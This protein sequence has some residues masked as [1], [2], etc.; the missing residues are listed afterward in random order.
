M[1]KWLHT[2]TFLKPHASLEQPFF[3]GGGGFRERG[4]KPWPHPHFAL[5][6]TF[7]TTRH[8]FGQMVHLG[9]RQF[10]PVIRDACETPL[11]PLSA[12]ARPRAFLTRL[13]QQNEHVH[14]SLHPAFSACSCGLGTSHPTFPAL[15]S[16]LVRTG[17]AAHLCPVLTPCSIFQF[18]DRRL[19]WRRPPSHPSQHSVPRHLSC[20]CRRHARGRGYGYGYCYL[21]WPA[22]APPHPVRLTLLLPFRCTVS[23]GALCGSSLDEAAHPPLC[24]LACVI[25]F[26]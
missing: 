5:H 7:F 19:R 9:S 11:C 18:H 20:C 13:L 22:L 3:L 14:T 21:G 23:C 15:T 24:I 6:P 17:S 4:S 10:L 16:L 8:V 1:G 12:S 2:C 25:V 26:H